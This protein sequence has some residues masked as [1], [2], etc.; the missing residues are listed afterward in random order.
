MAAPGE[1]GERKVMK[2]EKK[3]NGSVFVGMLTLCRRAFL[4]A[5]FG[6][7]STLPSRL[8]QALGP[9][10][11]AA[12]TRDTLRQESLWSKVSLMS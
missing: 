11:I 6:G 7:V 9:V 12:L 5:T 3:V 8:P 1:K 10:L 4:R 2:E